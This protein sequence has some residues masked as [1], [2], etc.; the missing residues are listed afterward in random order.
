MKQE[1]KIFAILLAYNASQTL[2]KFYKDLPKKLFNEIILFD[3]FST[4]NT[5]SLSQKL[6]IK[7]YKNKKNLGYGGNLKRAIKESLAQGADIIVDIHPDGEYKTDTIPLAIKLA[8]NGSNLVVGN[9]FYNLNYV[10][11]ESGMYFWK[12]APLIFLNKISKIIL[13]TKIDDLHQG[14]RIYNKNLFTEIDI[15]KNSDNY[16]FSFEI[17]TQAV[18]AKVKISQVPIKTSYTGT[19]RGAS[20]KNSIIYTLGVYKI[21]I[22]FILAKFG[23]DFKLF[24]KNDER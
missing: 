18:F 7:S 5:Y 14:F 1:S 9:R 22:I 15:N 3:D 20:L 19:K 4:D 13:S 6:G 23:F 2:E 12:I 8:K 10:L 16:L 24:K 17:I 21:L 11:K